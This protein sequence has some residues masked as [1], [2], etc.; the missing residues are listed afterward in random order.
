[1]PEEIP[2]DDFT[3]KDWEALD[4]ANDRVA[5]KFVVATTSSKGAGT[6]ETEN[7]VA[8]TNTDRI[9][10]ALREHAYRDCYIA[11]LT[12]AVEETGDVAEGIEVANVAWEKVSGDPENEPQEDDLWEALGVSK[13]EALQAFGLDDLAETAQNAELWQSFVENFDPS[14]SRNER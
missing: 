7:A 12:V 10:D 3:K 6:K 2:W 1:M 11:L 4:R 14:Q 8:L 9:A 13:V 5:G